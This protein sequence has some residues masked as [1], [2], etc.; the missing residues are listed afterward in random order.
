LDKNPYRQFGW[1]DEERIAI[2][3]LFC[4]LIGILDIRCVNVSIIKQNITQPPYPVL[5]KALTYSI[6]RIENDLRQGHPV[7]QF[8]ILTDEG[9]VGKMRYTSRRI[10]IIN[11]IPSKYGP[12]PYRREIQLLVEDPLRKESKES[13]LGMSQFKVV[14]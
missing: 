2:L 12:E 3:D 11:Y 7:E 14:R 9:R 4:D 6:Q 5:D 8:M 1:D 13:Y 10:Q